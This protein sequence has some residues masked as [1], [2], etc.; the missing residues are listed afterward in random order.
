[1]GLRGD[2]EPLVAAVEPP[3]LPGGMHLAQAGRD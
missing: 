1:M 3:F 2:R